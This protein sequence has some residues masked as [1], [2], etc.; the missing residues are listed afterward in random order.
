[1]LRPV[2]GALTSL[3]ATLLLC[4]NQVLAESERPANPLRE[5]MTGKAPQAPAGVGNSVDASAEGATSHADPAVQPAAAVTQDGPSR[6]LPATVDGAA[7]ARTAANRMEQHS[8]LVHPAVHQEPAYG[9]PRSRPKASGFVPRHERVATVAGSERVPPS[10]GSGLLLDQEGG[11]ELVPHEFIEDEIEDCGG[12]GGRA[13]LQCCCP[14]IPWHEFQLFAGAQGFTGPVNRGQAGSFGYHQGINWGTQ[15][16]R[17]G[18]GELGMQL[19]ARTTQTNLSG[20]DFTPDSRYQVFLTAGLFRRVDC[21]LQGGVAY[22][23]LSE[24]WYL[25]GDLSQIRGELSWM[26]PADH[27]LGFWFTS[28]LGRDTADSQVGN[29]APVAE[30]WEATDLY[31]FF[32]RHRFECGLES[33]IY[34]GFSGAGD[35]LLGN[36]FLVPL[37]D[38]WAVQANYT[39]LSPEQSGFPVGAQNESWNVGISV[40]WYPGCNRARS[41]DY[42]RPLLNVADN[43]SFITRRR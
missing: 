15:L 24:D 17:L 41:C 26:F 5:S 23:Y 1:M 3:L 29:R 4:G 43:G 14:M 36:D 10:V 39:Y 25:E 8:L 32:Y 31:A 40:V 28:G 38:N 11:D 13:C 19:G 2:L 34:A 33:R 12:C 7:R 30:T 27:E 20:A 35:G 22:D 18:G 6:A 42:Y 21:G 16:P 9:F 37:N